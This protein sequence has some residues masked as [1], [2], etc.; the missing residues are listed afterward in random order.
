M[1]LTS[2]F[3]ILS[4]SWWWT[5]MFGVKVIHNTEFNSSVHSLVHY[6]Y[7]RHPEYG[8]LLERLVPSVPGMWVV[9]RD[10]QGTNTIVSPL[11]LHFLQYVVRPCA[12]VINDLNPTSC[13]VQVYKTN[14]GVLV[15]VIS[16][17][18]HSSHL[19]HQHGLLDYQYE[20]GKVY[21]WDGQW[22][23]TLLTS[24]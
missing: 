4:C 7:G 24:K 18:G 23:I 16:S 13:Q 12:A 17:N 19:A 22:Y 9:I 1:L 15:C 5:C 11:Y 2:S 14:A 10:P 3:L 20:T 21:P 6:Q 8:V